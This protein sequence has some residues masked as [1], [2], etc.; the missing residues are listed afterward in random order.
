MIV[1][2]HCI[3]HNIKDNFILKLEEMDFILKLVETEFL[4]FLAS[5]L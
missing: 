4:S 1:P 5:Q 3:L 2:G